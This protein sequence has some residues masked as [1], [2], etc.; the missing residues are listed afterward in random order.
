MDNKT[1]Q[2][3]NYMNYTKSVYCVVQELLHCTSLSRRAMS[4]QS[5]CA[6]AYTVSTLHYHL[7]MVSWTKTC[8]PTE[9]ALPLV[10][11]STQQGSNLRA[12]INGLPSVDGSP[13]PVPPGWSRRLRV[14]FVDSSFSP[15]PSIIKQT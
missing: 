9:K 13:V 4:S 12:F 2:A 8:A 7:R 1:T 6:S 11:Y 14:T 5:Y 10:A 15:G 3:Y